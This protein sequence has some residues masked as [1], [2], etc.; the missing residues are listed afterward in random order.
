ML[1]GLKPVPDTP[2]VILI[3]QNINSEHPASTS[4]H[5]PLL[6]PANIPEGRK[7]IPTQ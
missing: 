7:R 4:N 6:T 1:W 2:K 3:V 5:F